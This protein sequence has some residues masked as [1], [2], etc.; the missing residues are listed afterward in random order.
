MDGWKQHTNTLGIFTW[1]AIIAHCPLR[2]PGAVHFRVPLCPPAGAATNNV[3][4]ECSNLILQSRSLV[5]D[6]LCRDAG[7]LFPR[8]GSVGNGS[9]FTAVIVGSNLASLASLYGKCGNADYHVTY[10]YVQRATSE[11]A[12]GKNTFS[13]GAISPYHGQANYH[14]YPS[15]QTPLSS[16]SV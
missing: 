3:A 10:K 6:H 8:P 11:T 16:D 2:E 5:L 9:C 7:T 12:A 14:H 1:R 15:H 13:M 4:Q